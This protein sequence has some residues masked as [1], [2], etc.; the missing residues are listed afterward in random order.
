MRKHPTKKLT[1]QNIND[2]MQGQL[3][4]K[5]LR[6]GDN[7]YLYQNKT[8]CVWK[9]RTQHKT[10]AQT[11]Y[12]W[13]TIGDAADISIT[14]ARAKA[15]E[16]RGLIRQNINV[17]THT[18]ETTLLGKKF[19]E[20]VDIYIQQ[21]KRNLKPQSKNKLVAVINKASILNNTIISKITE[22]DIAHVIERVKRKSPST[23]ATLLRELKS[24]FSFAYDEKYMINKL[25]INLKARYKI[26]HR[27]RYLDECKLGKLFKQL[28]NDVDIPLVIKVAIYALFITMLR[29]DELLTLAWEDVDLSHQKI[30]IRNAK[31]IDNFIVRIPHQLVEQLRELRQQMPNKKYVFSCRSYRYSG[32]T[33]CR[34]CKDLGIKYGIGEFTPHDARRTGMTLLSDRGHSYKVIDMAL[35]HVQQGVNKS[36]LKTHLSEPRAQLLQDYADLID[37]LA[38][39]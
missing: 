9:I 12:S 22:N 6:D 17:H 33:L 10:G 32:D 21:S 26:N 23:A 8:S 13:K 18:K 19:G 20:I 14:K 34:Y 35:G 4:G 15:E 36:Y 37:E 1:K 30:T 11:K 2:F 39:K 5:Y 16:M 31:R 29:R 24:I 27:T 38:Q 28:A 7:L 25:D 3:F